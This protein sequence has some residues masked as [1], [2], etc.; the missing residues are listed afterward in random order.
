MKRNLIYFGAVCAMTLVMASCTTD[1]PNSPG[2]EFM[3][4]MYRQSSYETNSPNANFADSMTNRMPV[5]GTIARGYYPVMADYPNN[6]SGY[7]WAGRYLKSP[8]PGTPEVLGQGKA[9]YSKF[10][11]QC[12]GESGGGDGLV[13]GKLPGPP[14]AYSGAL[15]DLPEGKMFWSVHYGK[16]LMGPHAPLLT[17]EER[18]KII[19]Y[20]QTLQGKKFD[21][22]GMMVMPEMPKDTAKKGK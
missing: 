9:L 7:V 10:C 19:R 18:W 11:A 16:G 5:S 14:P 15:K 6:D 2:F 20:V 12:H 22:N 8:I 17:T 1:D 13:A 3:P 4:D 21:D